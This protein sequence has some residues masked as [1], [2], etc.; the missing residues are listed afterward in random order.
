MEAHFAEGFFWDVHAKEVRAQKERLKRQQQQQKQK[1]GVLSN[2]FLGRSD[3]RLSEN[4]SPNIYFDEDDVVKLAK[5]RKEAR[6]SE[7]DELSCGAKCGYD[8]Y[9]GF[10][11]YPQR[12]SINITS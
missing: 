10:A 1:G 12:F 7:T 6:I 9:N 5:C 2:F 8:Y 4:T 3:R 11:L